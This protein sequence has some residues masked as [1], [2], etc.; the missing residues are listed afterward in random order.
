[1]G[2]AQAEAT[3]LRVVPGEGSLPDEVCEGLERLLDEL[4]GGSIPAERRRQMG[5]ACVARL[6]ILQVSGR[7][8]TCT[9][10]RLARS[11]SGPSSRL[12]R[13]VMRSSLAGFCLGCETRSSGASAAPGSPTSFSGIHLRLCRQ[14]RGDTNLN[15]AGSAGR[16]LRV[17]PGAKG[18][19]AAQQGVEADEAGH[20]KA[21]QL[22]SSVG[23][24]LEGL[25]GG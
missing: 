6:R 18:R 25:S 23:R 9:C 7:S 24:T 3:L 19:G 5:S 2:L 20:N 11:H 14:Y 17:T 21:S 4:L 10:S 12:L 13:R 15:A 1:M 22:N 16:G 8:A